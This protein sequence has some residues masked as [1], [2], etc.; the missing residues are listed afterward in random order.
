MSD[1][2]PRRAYEWWT[3]ERNLELIELLRAELPIEEIADRTGRSVTALQGQ[4]LNLLSPEIRASKRHA[5]TVLRSLVVCPD[6]DWRTGPRERFRRARQVYWDSDMNAALRE[7]WEQSRPLHELAATIGASEI[8]I[9]RQLM[10]LGLAENS[11]AAADHLGFDPNGTLAGQLRLAED[12]SASAVWVLVVDG[13]SGTRRITRDD[14]GPRQHLRHVSVHIDYDT[15][16]LTLSNLLLDHIDQGGDS[17]DITATIAE[18]TVGY[19]AVGAE[20][21]IARPV[22]PRAPVDLDQVDTAIAQ[23][24]SPPP[25]APTSSWSTP[26]PTPRRQEEQPAAA[27]PVVDLDVVEPPAPVVPSQQA[28]RLSLPALPE[29]LRTSLRSWR[30]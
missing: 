1:N 16:D 22:V 21:N 7:G 17:D 11:R 14:D 23:E 8:E 2:N 25:T 13:A 19:L 10:R 6:Y 26:L 18:R 12:R 24:P 29:R 3:D 20:H 30:K 15:A 5:P 9:A 28:T 4:C 27:E